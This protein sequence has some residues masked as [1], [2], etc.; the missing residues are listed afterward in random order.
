MV[1]QQCVVF[2]FLFLF[3]DLTVQHMQIQFYILQYF[4]RF[5]TVDLDLSISL[6]SR[7]FFQTLLRDP[8]LVFFLP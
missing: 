6:P 2:S 4:F 3:R 5:L 8:T 7:I 1:V